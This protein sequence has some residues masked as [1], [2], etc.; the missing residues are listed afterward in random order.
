MATMT[1]GNM[2]TH[3]EQGDSINPIT[4]ILGGDT[5]TYRQHG[6]V[7]SLLL[8]SENKESRLRN[9]KGKYYRKKM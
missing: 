9:I 2:Q 1:V 5:Q 6:D 7:I 8:F 4:K 3:R